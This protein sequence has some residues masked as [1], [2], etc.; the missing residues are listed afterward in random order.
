M[1]ELAQEMGIEF[2]W[3][4]GSVPQDRRRA[5]IE[6]FKHDPACRLFL[7]TDSGS[8]GLNLQVAS[9]V[10][11]LDLPWNPAKLEQRIARAW[12][13]NQMRTVDVINLVTEDSI[14]HSMLH[15][16]SEKQALA[17]GVLDGRRRSEGDEDAIRPPRVCRAH[18]AMMTP[19]AASVP[20]VPAERRMCDELVEAHGEGLLLLETHLCADDNEVML[21]V[22]EDANAAMLE[23]QRLA[24]ADGPRVEVID[25]R[26][27]EAMQ[28][29][30]GAG[31][32]PSSGQGQEVFRSDHLAV[33]GTEQRRQRLARGAE[34]I[35]RRRTQAAYG[36]AAR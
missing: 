7:S 4:T 18:E 32:L 30:A 5:E 27:Y 9:A 3:H 14:E 28:R 31:V 36:A 23:Q 22:L 26:S 34:R 20:V 25:R 12:R 16:L 1:R 35:R 21:I 29:L 15:L 11:N 10:I 8:V 24:A 19:P 2:A 33:P 6:R 13:K 17:D